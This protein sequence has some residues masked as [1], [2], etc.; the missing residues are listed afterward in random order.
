MKKK[1][2]SAL[3]KKA[4]RTRKSAAPTKSVP[5][6]MEMSQYYPRLEG[7]FDSNTQYRYIPVPAEMARLAFTV[8]FKEVKSR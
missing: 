4:P 3:K 1:N 8:V 6:L 5:V 7:L 2:V